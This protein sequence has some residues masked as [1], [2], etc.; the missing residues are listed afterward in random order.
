MQPPRA[1]VGH[2]GPNVVRTPV[3]ARGHRKH[4]VALP[5][6]GA[7]RRLAVVL[8]VDGVVRA[9]ALASVA[10]VKLCVIMSAPEHNQE[11]RRAQG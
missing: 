6:L 7:V 11:V 8:S 10:F 9:G 4:D 5:A 2:D 3:W 1:V